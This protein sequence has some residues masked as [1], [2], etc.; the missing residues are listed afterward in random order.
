V[1]LVAAVASVLVG[2]PG[3]QPVHAGSL[4][5]PGLT[6]SHFVYPG[7]VRPSLPVD[8]FA[9]LLSL[10]VLGMGAAAAFA[11]FAPQRRARTAAVTARIEPVVRAA[12][13]GFY[14]E[15]A[16]HRLGVPFLAAGR[17]AAAF[18]ETVLDGVTDAAG[19]STGRIAAAAARVRTVNQSLYLAGGVVVIV[20][21]TL[22]SVL[23]ATGHFWVHS[24]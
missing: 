20:V 19:A 17:L 22:I 14:I 6:F 15:R 21:I 13:R 10:L 16:A 1:A 2:L 4:S 8:Y 3:I 23:A 7:G 24:V 9:L 18:D 12:T 5:I 11:L